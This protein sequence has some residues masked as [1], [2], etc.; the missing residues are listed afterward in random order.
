M[1]CFSYCIFRTAVKDNQEIYRE[2][3]RITKNPIQFSIPT[4]KW[5]NYK[6]CKKKK[7]DIR[8]FSQ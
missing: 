6:K 2:M 1:A 8:F 5:E 4:L 3:T 7:K